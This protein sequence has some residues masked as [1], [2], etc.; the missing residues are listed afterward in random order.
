MSHQESVKAIVAFTTATSG[1]GWLTENVS[2]STFGFIGSLAT[3]VGCW[4]M[5]RKERTADSDRHAHTADALAR[6]EIKQAEDLAK[7][8]VQLAG[9]HYG[10]ALLGSMLDRAQTQLP[11]KPKD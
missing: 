9:L 10:N 7:I 2:M 11:Q 1:W 4:W 6:I 5:L 3:G 8:Q